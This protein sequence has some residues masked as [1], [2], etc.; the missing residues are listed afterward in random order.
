MEGDGEEHQRREIA[1]EKE[2]KKET[3]KQTNRNRD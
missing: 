2:R 1:A 3:N